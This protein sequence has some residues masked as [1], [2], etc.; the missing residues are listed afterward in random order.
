MFSFIVPPSPDSR[1]L[2]CISA[3]FLSFKDV[4]TYNRQEV[5]LL[6]YKKSERKSII[7]QRKTYPTCTLTKNLPRNSYELRGR[8]YLILSNSFV[9]IYCNFNINFIHE[10][11]SPKYSEHLTLS[12]LRHTPHLTLHR[13]CQQTSERVH[14]QMPHPL[15]RM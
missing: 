13:S 7:N 9:F 14:R 2:T 11:D 8:F 5:F 10:C 4:F 15:E 3:Y 6:S 1:M 12:A